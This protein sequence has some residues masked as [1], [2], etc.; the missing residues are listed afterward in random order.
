[1]GDLTGHVGP[2][3][4]TLG[5]LEIG[6]LSFQVIRHAVERVDETAKL[7]R[8]SRRHPRVE[9]A[10]GDPAGGAGEPVHRIGN[11]LGHPVSEARAEEHE[12]HRGGQ[13][14]PIELVDLVLDLSLSEGLGHRD[15]TTFAAAGADRCGRQEVAEPADFLDPDPRGQAVQHDVLVHMARCS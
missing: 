5:T 9:I 6:P 12:E 8:G 2:C 10:A 15:N 13:H 7:V 11:A 3:L 1:M 14:A 4:Q